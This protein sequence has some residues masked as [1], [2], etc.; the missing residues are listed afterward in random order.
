MQKN[1][2]LYWVSWIKVRWP[3]AKLVEES[4]KSLYKDFEIYSDDVFGKCMIEYFDQG[5]EF[6]NWS[7]IKKRCRELQVEEFTE[8]ATQIALNKKNKELEADK[9]TGLGSYLK[10]QG[11]NSLEEAIFYTSKRLYKLNQLYKP[12][13]E[14]FKQYKDMDFT[15]AK[16]NGFRLGLTDSIL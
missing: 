10:T 13:M 1:E 4:I 8:K 2:Y 9:P 14:A 5:H 3:N 16:E 6:I 12:S 7:D 15:Q 11:W